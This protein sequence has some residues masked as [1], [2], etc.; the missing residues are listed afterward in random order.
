VCSDGIDNDG[1]LRIDHPS[2]PGCASDTDTS[3]TEPPPGWGCG[4]GPE[5]CAALA[6]I[7]VA[8]APRRRAG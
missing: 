1:D 2:D 8:R 5:L 3:E 6:L 7:L 4:I